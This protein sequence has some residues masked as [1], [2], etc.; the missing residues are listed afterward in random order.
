MKNY[1]LQLSCGERAVAILGTLLALGLVLG[2]LLGL[3]WATLP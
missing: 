2:T 3:L 1:L